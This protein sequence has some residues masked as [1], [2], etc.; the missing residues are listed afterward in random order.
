MTITGPLSRSTVK[1]AP[2]RPVGAPNRMT[3]VFSQM[4][5][6]CP[7]AM[8]VYADC[9]IA[10]HQEGNLE[11]GTCEMEFATVKACFRAVRQS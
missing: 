8:K 9:V 5:E 3:V 6:T 4:K 2:H 10:Q 1:L 7:D 11:K